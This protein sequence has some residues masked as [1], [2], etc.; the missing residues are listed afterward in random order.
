MGGCAAW[1][2]RLLA[3]RL[4]VAR[5]VRPQCANGG[6]RC[7]RPTDRDQW[8]RSRQSRQCAVPSQSVA[9]DVAAHPG[10]GEAETRTTIAKGRSRISQDA[11]QLSENYKGSVCEAARCQRRLKSDPVGSVSHRR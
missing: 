5:A 1:G 2:P 11:G 6:P 8:G 7:T 3:A 10:T 9:N 4:V